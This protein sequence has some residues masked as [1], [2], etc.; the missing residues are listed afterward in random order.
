MRSGRIRIGEVTHDRSGYWG[1]DNQG[2]IQSK[3]LCGILYTY[4]QHEAGMELPFGEGIRH[5]DVDCMSCLVA[6]ARR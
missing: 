2:R 1:R 5:K 4:K 6:E 3:T